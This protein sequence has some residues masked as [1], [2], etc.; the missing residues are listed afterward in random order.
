MGDYAEKK[1][2]QWGFCALLCLLIAT[3]FKTNYH[4]L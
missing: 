2:V 3:A 1:Q 4:L